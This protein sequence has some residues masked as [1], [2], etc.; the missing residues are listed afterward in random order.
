MSSSA[1]FI[2]CNVSPGL[3]AHR[4]TCSRTVNAASGPIIVVRPKTTT[5]RRQI[6]FRCAAT[7]A[8]VRVCLYRGDSTGPSLSVATTSL[9]GQSTDQTQADVV[10]VPRSRGPGFASATVYGNQST[11]KSIRRESR[12]PPNDSRVLATA[13]DGGRTYI[14]G[15]PMI[16]YINNIS[17]TSFT[18]VFAP[19]SNLDESLVHKD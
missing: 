17:F 3:T 18:F 12:E 10:V 19:R 13:T 6:S 8:V 9:S 4:A 14:T 1:R 7:V 2:N 15:R 16:E 5:Y 11:K